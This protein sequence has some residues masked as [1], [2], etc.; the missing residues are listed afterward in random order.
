VSRPTDF[1][2]A[3]CQFNTVIKRLAGLDAYADS[4]AIRLDDP[5]IRQW[6]MVFINR[7][8]DLGDA[9]EWAEQPDY[10]LEFSTL[11]KRRLC[12]SDNHVVMF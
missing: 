9:W 8:T 1:P 3:D 7:N 5:K 11:V 12:R 4:W 2:K 6:L 10:P